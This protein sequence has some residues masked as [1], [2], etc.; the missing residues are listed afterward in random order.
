MTIESAF[1][2][3]NARELRRRLISTL[4]TGRRN[5]TGKEYE[6]WSPLIEDKIHD[7]DHACEAF[8]MRLAFGS[9]KTVS[10]NGY[11]R[12][13]SSA[14]AL[15]PLQP[16]VLVGGRFSLSNVL[17]GASPNSVAPRLFP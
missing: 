15:T 17:T 1:E 4:Q 6:E 14:T 12:Y 5:L 2:F 13:V 8:L 9:G 3:V 7:I 16:T 11:V 10:T